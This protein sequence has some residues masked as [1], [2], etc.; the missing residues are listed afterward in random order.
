MIR[1]NSWRPTVFFFLFFPFFDVRNSIYKIHTFSM[2]IFWFSWS[3]SNNKSPVCRDCNVKIF[4]GTLLH[5]K[6]RHEHFVAHVRD[7]FDRLND[8]WPY[9]WYIFHTIQANDQWYSKWLDTIVVFHWE[10]VWCI[11]CMLFVLSN[12]VKIKIAN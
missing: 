1:L 10:C 9:S 8:H 2:S 5:Q 4:L 3:I 11:F 12:L 7:E 6:W